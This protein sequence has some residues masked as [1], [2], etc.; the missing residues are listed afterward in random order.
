MNLIPTLCCG[1]KIIIPA[2]ILN[3][4]CRYHSLRQWEN[5]SLLRGSHYSGYGYFC[6]K[7]NH[8]VEAYFASPRL[9]PGG[10]RFFATVWPGMG[11]G[12]LGECTPTMIIAR[13]QTKNTNFCSVTE[14]NW[15]DPERMEGENWVWKLW[16]S[17]PVTCEGRL[18]ASVV[19]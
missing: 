18:R 4:T 12:E 10:P 5:Y 16:W 13:G 14:I 7:Q 9:L 8:R 17:P 19:S 11:N 15:R 3:L 2:L 6:K 1:N